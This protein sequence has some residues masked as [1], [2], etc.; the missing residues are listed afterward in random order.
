[1][2]MVNRPSS[3]AEL[4]QPDNLTD[5]M[6]NRLV[7]Y[8]I[9]WHTSNQPGFVDDGRYPRGDADI[10]TVEGR[11]DLIIR[12]NFTSEMNL[13]QTQRIADVFNALPRYGV[14]T[15]PYLPFAYADNVFVATERV[16]GQPLMEAIASESPD[17]HVSELDALWAN[18]FRYAAKMKVGR[19]LAAADANS[20]NQYMIG[21]VLSD[22]VTRARMVDLGTTAYDY[23]HFDDYYYQEE[24]LSGAGSVL[25]LEEAL[26][27]TLPAARAALLRAVTL[28]QNPSA[29]SEA[30]AKVTQYSLKHS[31]IIDSHDD[32]DLIRQLGKRLG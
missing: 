10:F 1:M 21:T 7:R 25:E 9:G 5:I 16:E 20:P 8:Q 15:L 32:E 12:A 30:Y 13:A 23:G 3:A 27:V 4:I 11:P 6:E 31:V 2:A 26:A 19:M 24:L 18:L 22:S 29:T 17:V 14:P 28:R